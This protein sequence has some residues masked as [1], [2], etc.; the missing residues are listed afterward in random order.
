MIW[1]YE[2]GAVTVPILKLALDRVCCAFC[3]EPLQT[4]EDREERVFIGHGPQEEHCRVRVCPVCGWWTKKIKRMETGHGSASTEINGAMGV[5]KPLDL[6]NQTAPLNEVRAYLAA[7]YENRLSMSPTLLEKTVA[8]V[9]GS[10]GYRT[11]VTGRSGDGGIDV[12][13]RGATG[14]TIGVQVKRYK[15]RIRAEAIRAFVGALILRGHPSGVFVTTSSFQPG[16]SE[17]ASL[18]TLL[19]TPVELVDARNFYDLLRI[20]QRVLYTRPDDPSAPFTGAKLTQ[21]EWSWRPVPG[22]IPTY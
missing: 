1:E 13:L 14:D 19:G 15:R 5:L 11:I 16:A 2:P 20:S 6:A 4:L 8:S 22:P 10:C 3:D 18:A 12:V 9:F 21:V 17:E 7:K